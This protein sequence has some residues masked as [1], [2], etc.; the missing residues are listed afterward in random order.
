MNV[1]SVITKDYENERFYSRR[2]NK[3]NLLNAKMNVS[4]VITK[5]YENQPSCGRRQNKPNLLNTQINSNFPYFSEIFNFDL[6]QGVLL[7]KFLVNETWGFRSP[8]VQL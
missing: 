5:D 3:P 1:S 6:A 4:S 7:L 8:D 2:K